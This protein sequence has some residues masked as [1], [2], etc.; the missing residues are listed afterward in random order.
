MSDD[1]IHH[2]AKL[3]LDLIL[4]VQQARMLHDADAKPSQI[5]GVYWIEAKSKLETT[6]PPTSHAGEW[7]LETDL[8]N[9]DALWSQIRQAT[10]DGLLGYKSKVSTAS[11]RGGTAAQS[12]QII[13]RTCDADDLADVERVKAALIAL[14]IDPDRL[15][16]QR[17]KA[18]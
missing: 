9:V 14:G 13:I 5:S 7:Q 17:D 4:R 1:N 11:R 8:A 12:R 18:E 6:R 2:P 15:H 16:Y 10:E 3:D